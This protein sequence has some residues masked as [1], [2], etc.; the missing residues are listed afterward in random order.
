MYD[1]QKSK[2]NI[3]PYKKLLLESPKLKSSEIFKAIEIAI[4]STEIEVAILKTK[5][6]IKTASRASITT[7]SMS[8][9]SNEPVVNRFNAGCTKKSHRWTT[10]KNG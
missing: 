5:A 2:S 4:P 1:L 3:V 9:H 7:G 10:M 6:F 8:N